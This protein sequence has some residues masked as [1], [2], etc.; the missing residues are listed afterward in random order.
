MEK[1]TLY[2]NDALLYDR[3]HTLATEYSV[4]TDLLVNIAIRRLIDDVELIRKLRAGH[5][6]L[7]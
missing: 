2:I 7:E 5:V 4:S 6:K 1:I 3:L